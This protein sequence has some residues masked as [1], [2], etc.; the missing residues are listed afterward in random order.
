MFGHL[1]ALLTIVVL[2]WGAV[3]FGVWLVWRIGNTRRG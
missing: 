1:L 3:A 2:A